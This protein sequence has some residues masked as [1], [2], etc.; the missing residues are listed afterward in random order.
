[1]AIGGRAP[2]G[3]SVTSTRYAWPIR[4]IVRSKLSK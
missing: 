4:S 3:E 1:L 2:A